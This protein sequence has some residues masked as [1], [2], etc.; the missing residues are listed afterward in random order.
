M[1]ASFASS[2]DLRQIA[3]PARH[4]LIFSTFEALLPGQALELINDHD[5][6]PLNAQFELRSPGQFSWNYLENGPQV[7]R[8][9]ISKSAKAASA[10]SGG[11][12]GGC[13]GG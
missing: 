4:P 2:I 12:C 5:P 13:C 10:A 7:W 11:C 3:P 6:Q 8:V 9:E 1:S